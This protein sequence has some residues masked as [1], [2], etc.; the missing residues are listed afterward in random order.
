VAN[1]QLSALA[2][3][4]TQAEV[5]RQLALVLAEEPIR[6]RSKRLLA[7]YSDQH[8]RTHTSA[9]ESTRGDQCEQARA[10]AHIEHNEL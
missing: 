5:S 6:E 9:R 4:R 8:G 3:D 2:P 10:A 1:L 7:L